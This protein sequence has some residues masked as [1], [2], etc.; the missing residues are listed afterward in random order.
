MNCA[1]SLLLVGSLM[2]TSMA[3]ATSTSSPWPGMHDARVTKVTAILIVDGKKLKSS[4]AY[5]TY[6]TGSILHITVV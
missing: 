4:R 5:L 3:N 2:T 1:I 6:H